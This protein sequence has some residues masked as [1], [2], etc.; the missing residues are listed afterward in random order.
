M[1]LNV[2]LVTCGLLSATLSFAQ[3][4]FSVNLP[5]DQIVMMKKDMSVLD[6]FKFSK[7]TKSEL[8]KLGLSELTNTTA[9]KWLLDR[10]EYVTDSVPSGELGKRLSVLGVDFNYD[11]PGI[12]PDVEQSDIKPSG[13]GVVVMSNLGAGIYSWGKSIKRLVSLEVNTEVG[14]QHTV[15]I[16]SPRSGIITVG[17][18]LFL[19]R[20]QVNN[21]NPAAES[22]SLARLSV[23]FHEAR[24]SD[25]N[26]KSL[27]F[28]HAVCGEGHDYQGYHACDRN[29]NGPYTVGAIFLKNFV[30]SCTTCSD[31]ERE[32]F[33]V[34]YLDSE[35]RVITVT[36]NELAGEIQSKKDLIEL[37]ELGHRMFKYMPG[38]DKKTIELIEVLKEEL[39]LLEKEQAS[40]LPVLSNKWDAS[41]EGKKF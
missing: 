6:K 14:R 3:I 34:R 4:K 38:E 12:L 22:N 23:F 5:S 35:N 19:D 7:L 24:H 39:A 40:A 36:N 18:G 16:S 13:K 11:N 17:E 21:V 32:V 20:L 37:K 30:T 15:Y 10:V 8:T 1:K 26:S 29:I 41:P 33:K 9:K 27:A 2:I 25:G 31:E 28:G